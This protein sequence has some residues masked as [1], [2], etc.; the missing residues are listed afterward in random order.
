MTPVDRR[1]SVIPRVGSRP[2]ESQVRGRGSAG[3]QCQSAALRSLGAK[4]R[5][6][7]VTKRPTLLAR[8][9]GTRTPPHEASRALHPLRAAE[10]VGVSA[11]C[12]SRQLL[13]INGLCVAGHARWPRCFAHILPA[14]TGA[15]PFRPSSSV[16]RNGFEHSSADSGAP[17]AAIAEGCGVPSRGRKRLLPPGHSRRRTLACPA[18]L[19]AV[20]IE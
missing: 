8:G 14:R 20:E 2:E 16:Q 12:P 7:G 19:R 18:T 11:G 10:R 6:L 9:W 15:R 5:R 3:W 4:E 13:S 17:C 1:G